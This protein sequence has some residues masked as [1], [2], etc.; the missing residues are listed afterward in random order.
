M[1]ILVIAPHAD[2]EVLGMGGTIARMIAHGQDVQVAILTGHGSEPHPLWPPAWWDTIRSECR[3]ALK[4]L[5][6]KQPIFRELPAACLDSIPSYKINKVIQ[7]LVEEIDPHE[8]YV[9]FAFDL[10][11][12]HGAIAYGVTVAARP[13]LV[14]ARK[15]QRILAYETLSETHL[16]PPYLTPAFQPNV[17]VDIS[18]Y[19]DLKIEAMSAYSSQMQ[20]N[21]LPRSIGALRALAKLRGAHIGVE[22]GE[23]FVM[24]GEYQR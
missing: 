4:I 24:L 13:Y 15:I 6:C 17:F 19:I 8:I 18:R 14:T 1:S 2:D 9:P 23:G 5:G 22:A 20:S 21:N 7:E 16:A 3:S 11:K 12:D 10:H